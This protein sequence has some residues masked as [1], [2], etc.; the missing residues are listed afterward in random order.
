VTT[1][2]V[3]ER[4]RRS[5]ARERLAR[6]ATLSVE[7]TPALRIGARE[8]PIFDPKDKEQARR[9]ALDEFKYSSVKSEESKRR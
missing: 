9:N 7:E 6:S 1:P 8:R 2:K 3:V 4:V 5:E